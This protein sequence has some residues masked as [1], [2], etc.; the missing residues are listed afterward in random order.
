M[1]YDV[2]VIGAGQA[3]LSMGYFLKQS[4]LSFVILD[5]Q[6]RIGD[7]WRNRYDSLVLFTPRNYSSLP[8]MVLQ[9]NPCGFPTKDEIA[10]YLESYS[11]QFDLPIQLNTEVQEVLLENKIFKIK[12]NDSVMLAKKVVITTGPFHTPNIPFLSK[13]LSKEVL[14]IHSANYKNPSQLKDGPVLVVGGG[15]SGSQIAVELSNDR[16]TYLS[17]GQPIR[18]IPTTIKGRSIFWI[19]D[20]LGILNAKRD[21][22]IGTIIQ[23]KGDPIFGY[24][25]KE[26]LKNK[27]IFLK[28]RTKAVHNN[29]MIFEDGSSISTQNVIWATGF[30]SNYSFIK[31]PGVTNPTSGRVIHSRGISNVDGLFFLGLPWQNKRGSALLLGVGEDAQYLFQI[32]ENS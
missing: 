4:N 6:K 12:A 13:E 17:I 27:S 16:E 19:F 24:E 11:S 30:N 8:G 15:N 1:V 22:F 28:G 18:F 9:G 32:I 20:K 21:S 2:I 7:V 23:K 3:G 10:D 26:K 5:N 25:L 29:T 31:I 14:Q